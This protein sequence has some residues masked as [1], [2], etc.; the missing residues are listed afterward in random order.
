MDLIDVCGVKN[1]AYYP[2]PVNYIWICHIYCKTKMYD[3]YA[4]AFRIS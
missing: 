1:W 2:L 3:E 4:I